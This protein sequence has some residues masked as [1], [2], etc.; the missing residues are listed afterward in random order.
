MGSGGQGRD[1]VLDS[2]K[3]HPM[4]GEGG[5]KGQGGGGRG[6]EEGG[7]GPGAP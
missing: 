6:E 5:G 1:L 4:Y 3:F 7:Q 2:W